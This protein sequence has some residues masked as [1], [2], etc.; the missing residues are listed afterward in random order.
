M[1]KMCIR[2]SYNLA[3]IDRAVGPR[4]NEGR[5]QS[6]AEHTL[7]LIVMARD[8]IDEYELDLDKELVTD[9]IIMHDAVEI[10]ADDT[11][12]GNAE[13]EATK[14]HRER[15]GYTILEDRYKQKPVSY[16]HL[17]VYKRQL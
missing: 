3:K 8:I 13:Q 7:N 12:V 14:P 1:K 9:L 4:K 11:V 10:Y 16:T 15:A 2:D 17:D 5:R 6:V